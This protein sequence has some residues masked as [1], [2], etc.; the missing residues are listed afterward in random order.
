MR[1]YKLGKRSNLTRR[2][3]RL[4]AIYIRAKF[5]S[6]CAYPGCK[7]PEEQLQC[8]HI[9]G[10]KAHPHWRFEPWNGLLL[11]HRHH[12]AFDG[13]SG[14]E[15]QYACKDRLRDVWYSRFEKADGH[16][17]TERPWTMDQLEEKAEQLRAMYCEHR[18]LPPK[19]PKGMGEEEWGERIERLYTAFASSEDESVGPGWTVAEVQ[20]N[21]TP[22]RPIAPPLEHP[23][24]EGR[25]VM[26]PAEILARI[27]G[28]PLV[29]QEIDA[30]RP[31]IHR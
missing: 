27:W 5:N 18:G 9:L 12:A 1:A 22:S 15:K 30:S 6:R 10:K 26:S 21:P 11:C 4:H 25:Q 14:I 20:Y 2:L 3:T 24:S 28:S 17:R 19:R 29:R 16:R 31:I 23:G 7:S 13:R 8:A